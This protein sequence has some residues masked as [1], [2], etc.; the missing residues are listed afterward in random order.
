LAS[1]ERGHQ[2]VTYTK[3]YLKGLLV[4]GFNPFEKY[5]RQLGNL[6]QI[7]M[8]IKKYLKPPP[9]LIKLNTFHEWIISPI[10]GRRYLVGGF[11]PS[12]K[13]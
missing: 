2:T 7:G 13:Y 9:I 3:I 10:H 5:E 1:S 12:Q 4:G 6:P 8:N 11:N